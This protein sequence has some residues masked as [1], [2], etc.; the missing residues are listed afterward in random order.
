MA[1]IGTIQKKVSQ[2]QRIMGDK[3]TT[4]EGLV[5]YFEY[6][7]FTIADNATSGTLPTEL[8]NVIAAVFTPT[9]AGGITAAI[10]SPLTVASSAITVNSTDPGTSGG[11]FAY[12]LIGT[13]ESA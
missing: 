9:N 4:V 11:S 5:L 2:P 1:D 7:T 3:S 10:W 8:T 12:F 6:G 13:I